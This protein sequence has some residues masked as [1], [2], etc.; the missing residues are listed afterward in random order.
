[1]RLSTITA[2]G[3]RTGQR[4][5]TYK[6]HGAAF[7]PR[8][9]L[10]AAFGD[11]ARGELLSDPAW[12]KERSTTCAPLSTHSLRKGREWVQISIS[13]YLFDRHTSSPLGSRCH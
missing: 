4:M 6:D 11:D 2:S 9:G 13:S 3:Q 12:K 10:N 1:M 5:K 8:K 7:C